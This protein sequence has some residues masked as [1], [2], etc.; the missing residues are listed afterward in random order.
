[1]NGRVTAVLPREPPVGVWVL[2]QLGARPSLASHWAGL[3]RAKPQT[4][5]K[6]EGVRDRSAKTHPEPISLRR[7]I[8][9][10]GRCLAVPG[11]PCV[12]QQDWKRDAKVGSSLIPATTGVVNSSEQCMLDPGPNRRASSGVCHSSS[13]EAGWRVQLHGA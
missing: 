13:S 7:F 11:T 4:S 12:T 5:Y 6:G 8:T 1:M 3:V 2:A 9:L 10:S